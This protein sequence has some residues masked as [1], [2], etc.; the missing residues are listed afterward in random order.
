MVGTEPMVVTVTHMVT[1]TDTAMEDLEH[2]ADIEVFSPIWQESMS[3][4]SLENKWVH[5]I[6]LIA[7]Y[8][9]ETNVSCW[10]YIYFTVFPR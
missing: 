10:H 2:M 1:E 5:N 4:G 3:K 9:P 6:M 7:F 8:K